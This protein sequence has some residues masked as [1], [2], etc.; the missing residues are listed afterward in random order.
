MSRIATSDRSGSA[1]KAATRP[2]QLRKLLTR[3]S[4]ATIPQIQK[5]FGW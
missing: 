5:S 1:K 2:A 3:K 4:G